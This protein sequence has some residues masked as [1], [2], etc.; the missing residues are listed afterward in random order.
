MHTSTQ[1][2]MHIYIDICIYVQV[3]GNVKSRSILSATTISTIKCIRNIYSLRNKSFQFPY[4]MTF[5]CVCDSFYLATVI[6]MFKTF[7]YKN[8]QYLEL[9]KINIIRFEMTLKS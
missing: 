3:N 5:I 9:E 4:P 6:G 2:Y 8:F 7:I 1:G